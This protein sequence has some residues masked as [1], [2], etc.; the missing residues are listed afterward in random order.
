MSPIVLL[1]LSMLS[2]SFLSTAQ[3]CQKK[4]E[5]LPK[6][7]NLFRVA[8]GESASTSHHVIKR[9]RVV[10]SVFVVTHLLYGV[11]QSG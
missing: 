8:A 10:S 4:K 3:R 2:F 11:E 6:R 7:A 9:R 5:V 1:F